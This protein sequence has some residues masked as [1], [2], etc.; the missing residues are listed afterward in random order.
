ML[1][2][3]GEVVAGASAPCGCW[4]IETKSSTKR[5]DAIAA[6]PGRVTVHC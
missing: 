3:S 2:S 6:I 1:S 5:A 4:I